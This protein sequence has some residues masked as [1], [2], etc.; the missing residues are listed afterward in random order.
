MLTILRSRR[1]IDAS[2][3]G[4][5]I[6]E[7]LRII[8]RGFPTKDG[9]RVVYNTNA[10]RKGQMAEAVQ[11]YRNGLV[12]EELGNELEAQEA[13]RQALNTGEITFSIPSEWAQFA[14]NSTIIAR[15]ES[16]DR[17]DGGGTGINIG[18][19]R[20][21]PSVSLKSAAATWDALLAGEDEEAG[22]LDAANVQ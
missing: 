18:S 3:V 21:A 5:E 17:K 12:Q 6:T 14:P 19:V 1:I 9:A 7:G 2:M 11:H 8:G 10:M 22:V 20:P 13:Y 15:V 16:F 4:M